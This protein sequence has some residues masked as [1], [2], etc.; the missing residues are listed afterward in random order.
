MGQMMNN[1][2]E[3]HPLDRWTFTASAATILILCVPLLLMPETAGEVINRAYDVITNSL[4]TLY[5]WYAIGALCFLGYHA[6]SRFGGVRL[7]PADSSPEF[8]TLSW[9][10]MLFCAG[11]GGV[12]LLGRD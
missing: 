5:L 7:G 2:R 1:T 11:I 12:A 6:F 10:A 8:A 3:K 9:I 4:G